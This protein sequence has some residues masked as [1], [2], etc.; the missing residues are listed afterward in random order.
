MLHRGGRCTRLPV[1][2]NGDRSGLGRGGGNSASLGS[3]G[4]FTRGRRLSCVSASAHQRRV[5][6]GAH[7]TQTRP[8]LSWLCFLHRHRGELRGRS[9]TSGFDHPCHGCRRRWSLGGSFFFATRS[10]VTQTAPRGGRFCRGS[11]AITALG[12]L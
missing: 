7:R 3:A 1:G 4:F 10:A 5:C 6:F 11:S 2:Y 9:G 8:W 12:S